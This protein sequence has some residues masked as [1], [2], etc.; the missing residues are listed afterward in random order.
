MLKK[1]YIEITNICNLSCSFCH[2]TKRAP[3][4]MSPAELLSVMEKLKGH[5]KFVYFHLLG[6]PLLHPQLAELLD[7]SAKAGMRTCITT[8][9]TL[10]SEKE[11][12]LLNA[13]G[14][15]KVS[16][17]LH[18]FEANNTGRELYDYLDSVWSVCERL[19]DKGTVCALRLWNAGGEDSLN[20]SITSFILN[21]TGTPMQETRG[22]YKLRER[23]YLELA[24]KFDWPD[25]S[26]P[27][28]SVQFCYGLR[29]QIGI[30]CDGTVVPCCLDAD[31]SIPLG[32]IFSD[33]LTDIL[34]SPRAKAMYEGFSR[35]CPT[36]ELCRHCGYAARFS[37]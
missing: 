16:V 13:E 5:T 32:N 19:A 35:R 9:G 1:A 6:E 21:K 20:D 26:A 30:L 15:H 18:S 22:G 11:D 10:L 8:N 24:S 29:D 33:E 31:G 37:I 36:E 2:G 14:L 28:A 17:S 34:N 4:Y 25:G 23:M 7:I 27:E 12:V 3:R